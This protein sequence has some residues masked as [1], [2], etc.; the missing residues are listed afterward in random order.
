M[1]GLDLYR[2]VLR[3]ISAKNGQRAG[4]MVTTWADPSM[5]IRDAEIFL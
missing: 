3:T 2:A 4:L 5:A 1:F